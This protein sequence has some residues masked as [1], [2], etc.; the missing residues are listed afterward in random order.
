MLCFVNHCLSF[1]TFSVGHRLVYNSTMFLLYR[2]GTIYC[3]RKPIP[4]HNTQHSTRNT[5]G[6]NRTLILCMSRA[7]IHGKIVIILPCDNAHSSIFLES[8]RLNIPLYTL[9]EIEVINVMVFNPK[10]FSYILA[11]NYIGKRSQIT[12][13][14]TPTCRKLVTNIRLY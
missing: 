9:N 3:Y 13:R 12:R 6:G 5:P 14:K 7:L 4:W 1:C 10:M 8:G 2:V 11:L